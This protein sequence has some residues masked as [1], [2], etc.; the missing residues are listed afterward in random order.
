MDHHFIPLMHTHSFGRIQGNLWLIYHFQ[1]I[2]SHA[3]L[4]CIF[5]EI[6][7]GS[8]GLLYIHLPSTS[9]FRHTHIHF[10]FSHTFTWG[11]PLF[12]K[13]RYNSY[14]WK[15]MHL[16]CTIQR[17]PYIHSAAWLLPLFNFAHFHHPLTK[18]TPTPRSPCTLILLNGWLVYTVLCLCLNRKQSSS[19]TWPRSRKSCMTLLRKI[20]WM[21]MRWAFTFSTRLTERNIS[22][23]FVK[24][25][26]EVPSFL[27]WD[28]EE[29]LGNTVSVSVLRRQWTDLD[30]KGF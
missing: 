23:I 10:S 2:F 1:R 25:H 8:P 15:F 3:P 20:S 6:C 22:Y 14:S 17:F 4:S 11:W 13:L 5:I 19:L 29:A 27:R 24:N 12:S 28:P 30:K 21:T 18:E 9:L 26:W 16:K 7:A